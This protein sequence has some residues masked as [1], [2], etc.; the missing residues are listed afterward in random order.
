MSGLGL[1]T[2][3][4]EAGEHSGAR[5]QARMAMEH[6]RPVLLTDSVITNTQWARELADGRRPNVYPVGGLQEVSEALDRIAWM[7]SD[8][9]LDQVIPAG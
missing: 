8:A 3:V 6:G 7:T 1:A 5:A 9:V 2:I 4:V